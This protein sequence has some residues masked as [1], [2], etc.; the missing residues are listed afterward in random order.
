MPV[1]TF[2]TLNL[3]HK[4]GL[5]IYRYGKNQ[6]TQKFPVTLLKETDGQ[7]IHRPQAVMA[8]FFSVVIFSDFTENKF[9]IIKEEGGWNFPS[10][11]VQQRVTLL[12]AAEN[13][14]EKIGT[15]V[16][17]QGLLR[18]EHTPF[19]VAKSRIRAVFSGKLPS[20]PVLGEKMKWVTKE[21]FLLMNLFDK[22]S[23]DLLELI[24]KDVP[25][26]PTSLIVT[27]GS[28]YN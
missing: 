21:E 20:P 28:P 8:Y 23:A 5:E 25:V 16:E 3:R 2:S 19:D 1:E 6:N 27:E 18:F 10:V 11:G 24:D 14:A 15:S 12:K 7:V 13:V 22:S 4:E 26:Y 9:L 17:I